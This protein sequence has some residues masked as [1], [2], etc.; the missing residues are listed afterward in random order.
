VPWCLDF[1]LCEMMIIIIVPIS[2]ILKLWEL[3]RLLPVKRLSQRLAQSNNMWQLTTRHHHLLCPSTAKMPH[4]WWTDEEN[5][6]FIYNEILFSY[7]E[8]WNFVICR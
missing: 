1:L 4:Y 5:V 7:K 6:V 2:F 8:E 3:A